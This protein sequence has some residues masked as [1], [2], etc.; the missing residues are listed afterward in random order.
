MS[1]ILNRIRTE[2]ALVTGAV[3]ALI[4]LGVALARISTNTALASV[5]RFYVSV[6]R[7]TPLLLQLFIVF[8]ALPQLGVVIDPFP[9]AVV[10]FSL[11]V[12][13][14]AAEVIRAAREVNPQIRVLA[15]ASYL[16]DIPFMQ[17][18]GADFNYAE[19][20]AQL[21]EA[22]AQLRLIQKLRKK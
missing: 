19:A 12:G 22:I 20:A 2:P 13:G 16:R 4:A 8:Y 21:A 18:A 9:A 14:Y 15:R 5:A 10:A 17:H 11:N 1:A 7:G 3:A 6:I